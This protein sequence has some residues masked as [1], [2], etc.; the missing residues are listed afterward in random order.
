MI[1]EIRTLSELRKKKPVRKIDGGWTPRDAPFIIGYDKAI[2]DVEALLRRT[3]DPTKTELKAIATH[4]DILSR[5]RGHTFQ[6]NLNTA[7]KQLRKIIKNIED[8]LGTTKDG[9]MYRHRCEEGDE[10]MRFQEATLTRKRGKPNR[11]LSLGETV[12]A[13]DEYIYSNGWLTLKMSF[14]PEDKIPKTITVK[15]GVLGMDGKQADVVDA[16]EAAP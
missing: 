8:L 16:K 11:I 1:S 6:Y 15:I 5:H 3:L 14:K 12:D 9:S 13:Y 2:D 4:L 10:E 7:F